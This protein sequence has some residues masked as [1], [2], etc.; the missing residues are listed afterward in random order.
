MTLVTAAPWAQATTNAPASSNPFSNATAWVTN[1][2]GANSPSPF[3]NATNWV[4]NRV[5]Q[6]APNPSLPV[7]YRLSGP[8]L[9]QYNAGLGVLG[10]RSNQLGANQRVIDAS[11][12]VLSLQQGLNPLYQSQLAARGG[13][14]DAQSR[15]QMLE[16]AYLESTGQNIQ[17]TQAEAEGV[18]NASQNVADL[19]NVAAVKQARSA[20]DQ[21]ARAYGVTPEEEINVPMGQQ[22]VALPPGVRAAARPQFEYLSENAQHAQHNRE[23]QL[24]TAKNAVELAGSDVDAA[25]MVAARAG[26]SLDE[27]KLVVQQASQE[28][29]AARLGASQAGLDLSGANFQQDVSQMPFNPGEVLYTDPRTGQSSYMSPYDEAMARAGDQQT[30]RTAIQ[31]RYGNSAALAGFGDAYLRSLL[32]QGFATEADVRA[33]LAAKGYNQA[34]I[35]AIIKDASN[36]KKRG[37]ASLGVGDLLGGGSGASGGSAAPA[38]SVDEAEQ[39]RIA[40]ALGLM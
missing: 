6:G 30:Q 21:R 39:L 16:R 35:E 20:D 7:G 4:T 13:V 19:T 14:L 8:A 36:D 2:S 33:A 17:Q 25:Q 40:Q 38:P 5:Q 18:W 24:E 10:A 32:V 15:Q 31:A 34:K 28:E 22:G 12:R 23:F 29:D 3:S 1:R 9:G 26:L 11:G 27:A 37:G